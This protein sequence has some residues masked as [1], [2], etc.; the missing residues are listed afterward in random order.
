[1]PDMTVDVFAPT[2]YGKVALRKLAPIPENFRLYSAGW[3]EDHPDDFSV[4]K[5]SGAAFRAAKTGPNKGKLS[6]LIRGTDR[7]VYVTKEE[8]NAEA[9]R[10]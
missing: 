1:M 9:S 10:P 5:V 2:P 8:I 4:M 3:M 7:T 6:I